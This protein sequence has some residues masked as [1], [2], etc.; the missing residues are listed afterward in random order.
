MLVGFAEA[1]AFV[2]TSS[3]EQEKTGACATA[4]MDLQGPQPFFLRKE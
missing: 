3:S 4:G 1:S 2:F